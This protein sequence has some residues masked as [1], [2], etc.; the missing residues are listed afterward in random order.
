MS[1]SHLFP[2]LSIYLVSFY[3]SFLSYFSLSFFFL[4]IYKHCLC[5]WGTVDG[6]HYFLLPSQITV[7]TCTHSHKHAHTTPHARTIKNRPHVHLYRFVRAQLFGCLYSR[8]K[9]FKYTVCALI[10]STEGFCIYFH[11][12]R[13]FKCSRSGAS[14]CVSDSRILIDDQSC[15]SSLHTS[16][17]KNPS[18]QHRNVRNSQ[19]A[20][21][22]TPQA[23][24]WQCF[25]F[26][27]V[28]RVF[29]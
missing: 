28:R 20:P 22:S 27:S 18:H 21:A 6:G 16:R 24:V 4:Y 2:L 23:A 1:S 3:S 14:P 25:L 5:C 8:L 26:S 11:S 13:C 12:C 7:S 15:I 9:A 10:V 19:Y 29:A 17:E